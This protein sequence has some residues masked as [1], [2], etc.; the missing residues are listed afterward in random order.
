MR[1]ESGSLQEI[2]QRGNERTQRHLNFLRRERLLRRKTDKL[3]YELI[4][5]I[6]PRI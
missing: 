6:P 3:F 1:F 2:M 4:R 5:S